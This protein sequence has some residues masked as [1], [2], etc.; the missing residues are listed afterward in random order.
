[1]VFVCHY[2]GVVG[3]FGVVVNTPRKLHSAGPTNRDYPT[4]VHSTLHTT[5]Y[6]QKVAKII[7]N[8]ETKEEAEAALNM[9]RNS[10][11][12]GGL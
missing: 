10:L 12:N 9:I 7:E 2:G 4:A 1:V 6:Y 8:A 3:Y 11:L 5:K